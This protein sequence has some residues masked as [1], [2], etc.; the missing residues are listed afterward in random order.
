MESKGFSYW[1]GQGRAVGPRTTQ[2]PRGPLEESAVPTRWQSG[3]FLG[4]VVPRGAADSLL[5]GGEV[6]CLAE[7]SAHTRHIGAAQVNTETLRREEMTRVRL[8]DGVILIVF[9]ILK[10]QLQKSVNFEESLF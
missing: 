4:S 6:L 1:L 9:L 2:Y 10:T 7:F 5:H 8:H 3:G